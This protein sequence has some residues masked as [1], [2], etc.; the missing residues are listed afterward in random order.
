MNQNPTFMVQD[1]INIAIQ[2]SPIPLPVK[3]IRAMVLTREIKGTSGQCWGYI[4]SLTS[5]KLLKKS[6][7]RFGLNLWLQSYH[8]PANCSTKHSLLAMYCMY[9]SLCLF[10]S[11]NGLK[12][13]DT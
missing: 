3:C 11:M 7:Y 6:I 8:R 9:C 5:K 13:A 1:K 12:L 2:V 10:I 4:I